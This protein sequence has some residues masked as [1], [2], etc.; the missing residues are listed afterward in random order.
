METPRCLVRSVFYEVLEVSL[1]SLVGV[2]WEIYIMPVTT[3]TNELGTSI[4][5][6][7]RGMKLC[8]LSWYGECMV[9]CLLR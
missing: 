7:L 5:S 8:S 4:M 2:A 1:N 3:C 6:S 9:G